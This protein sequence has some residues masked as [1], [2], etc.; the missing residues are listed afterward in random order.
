[1]VYHEDG[2]H[3]SLCQNRVWQT[4][5]CRRPTPSHLSPDCRVAVTLALPN[6]RVVDA[7]VS[8]RCGSTVASQGLLRN[9]SSE[10]AHDAVNFALAQACRVGTAPQWASTNRFPGGHVSASPLGRP[11]KKGARLAGRP[12]P[13]EKKSGD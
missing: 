5:L 3:R 12:F 2:I 10:T 1:M 8:R 11:K 6:C 4:P 9:F 13:W 7:S